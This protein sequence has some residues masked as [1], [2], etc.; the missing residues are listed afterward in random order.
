MSIVQ[1]MVSKRVTPCQCTDTFKKNQVLL[2][3]SLLKQNF[4]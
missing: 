2:S 4:K 3:R 1:K